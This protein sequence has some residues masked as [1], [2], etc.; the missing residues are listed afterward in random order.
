MY[1]KWTDILSRRYLATGGIILAVVMLVIIAVLVLFRSDINLGFQGQM[2]VFFFSPSDG[3][4]APEDRPWPQGN[5]D[6]WIFN[7][8]WILM[9]GPNSNRLAGVWPPHQNPEIEDNWG[10]WKDWH[11]DESTLVLTFDESYF[12]MQPL[13]EA[14]FRSAITLTMTSFSFIDEV[15]FIVGETE[16][17]ESAITIANAPELSPARISN[18]RL[19]LYYMDAS[20]EGL[21]REYYDAIDVDTHPQQRPRVAAERLIEGTGLEDSINLIPPETRI[22]AVILMPETNSIYVNLSGDFVTRFTGGQVQAHH[23]I[24]SIVNT[25]LANAGGQVR[26]VFFLIDSARVDS[27]HGVPDFALGFEYDPTVMLGYIPPEE[28]N[29]SPEDE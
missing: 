20:G 24:K 3:T 10:I 18:A 14:L 22:R 13:Q 7:A 11:M 12:L 2:Q 26:Q 25:V 4:L 19:I 1:K 16:R 27:F 9:G 21:V 15:R 6:E 17:T 8:M 28:L 5:R 23:M 29:D